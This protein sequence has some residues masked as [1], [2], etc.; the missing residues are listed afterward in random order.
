MNAIDVLSAD[1][2]SIRAILRKYRSSPRHGTP[3]KR[4]FLSRMRAELEIH[5][6]MAEKV[7]YPACREA[8]VSDRAVNAAEEQ[9]RDVFSLLNDLARTHPV[10]PG[11]DPA[12]TRLWRAVEQHIRSEESRIFPVAKRRMGT[13]RLEDLAARLVEVKRKMAPIFR[14][15]G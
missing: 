4:S 6:R 13:Q 12:A 1:H 5:S 2:E 8:G 7:W 9:L 10:D 11:F 3:R 14:P 15:G